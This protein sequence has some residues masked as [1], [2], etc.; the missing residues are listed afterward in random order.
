MLVLDFGDLSKQVLKASWQQASS[1]R[2]VLGTLNRE[3]FTTSSLAISKDATVIAMETLVNYI[4][5]HVL[6]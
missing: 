6:E 5:A 1:F 3:S 2:W 4:S